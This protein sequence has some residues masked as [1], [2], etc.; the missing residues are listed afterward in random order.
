MYEIVITDSTGSLTL[1]ALEV[2]LTISPI[3]G[4]TDVQTLDYNIYTDFTT[5]KKLISHSWAYL[6]E[7]Q[8]NDLKGYYERQFTL[9]QYPRITISELSITDMTAKMTLN[10]QAII[11]QCGTVSNVTVSFRESKQN[12]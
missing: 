4:S 1:P 6:T 11:D 10:P 3:E 2:P 12:P 9:F 7:D 5:I 8:Y